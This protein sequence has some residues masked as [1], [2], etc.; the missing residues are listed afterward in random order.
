[1]PHLLGMICSKQ[2]WLQMVCPFFT[3]EKMFATC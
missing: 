1:M 2:K 3:H